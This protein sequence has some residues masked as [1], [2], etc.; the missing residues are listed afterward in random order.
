MT[1]AGRLSSNTIPLSSIVSMARERAIAIPTTVPDGDCQAKS[2]RDAGQCSAEMMENRRALPVVS[3]QHCSGAWKEPAVR[4][5]SRRFPKGKKREERRCPPGERGRKPREPPPSRINTAPGRGRSRARE[6]GSIRPARCRR[7]RRAVH[8]GARR[9]CSL[10]RAPMARYPV[11][12][13]VAQL[14]QLGWRRA[15]PVSGAIRSHSASEFA[16]IAFAARL[17]SMNP[18]SAI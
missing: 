18:S 11:A 10:G 17:A 2:N 12:I 5:P 16:R 4:E 3:S 13:S 15:A 9:N 7:F 8:R 14:D 6:Q 1:K